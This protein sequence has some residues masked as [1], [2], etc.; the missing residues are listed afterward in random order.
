[1]V[2]Q[3]WEDD[4]LVH[5]AANLGTA[6]LGDVAETILTNSALSVRYGDSWWDGYDDYIY[7]VELTLTTNPDR[8]PDVAG[9]PGLRAAFG[10]A[11]HT[12]RDAY[13]EFRRGSLVA[14][15]HAEVPV[16]LDGDRI[17]RRREHLDRL[18]RRA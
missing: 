2:G 8:A 17:R 12:F 4:L 6:S 10:A 11:V 14:F 16:L 18:Q 5:G 1:M 3:D 9:A 13:G 15:T 7:D